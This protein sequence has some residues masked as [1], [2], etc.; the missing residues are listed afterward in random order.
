[1]SQTFF[2]SDTH[3]GHRSIC[4]YRSQFVTPKE[5]DEYIID[6]WNKTV[7]KEKN[8]VWCLGD[9][10]IKNK[11]YD[12]KS[13][14]KSLRGTIHLIPGNH[15]HMEAYKDTKVKIFPGMFKKYGYWLS[16]CPIHP[17]ELRGKKNIHGHV[18]DKTINDKNYYNVC[19]EN[20]DYKPIDLDELRRITNGPKTEV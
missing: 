16:H 8:I 12:F 3:F 11:Y 2:I 5:H 7:R 4:K 19:V 10:C 15:C 6:R 9:M 13:I 17:V 1:M 14:I 20:I 18:H